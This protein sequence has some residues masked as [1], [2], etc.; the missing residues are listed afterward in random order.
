MHAVLVCFEAC[1]ADKVY[2]NAVYWYVYQL[3]ASYCGD[4]FEAQNE[5]KLDSLSPL[6]C[7]RSVR[8]LRWVLA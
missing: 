8:S 4:G 2:I 7:Y 1:G 3:Y 6:L 5:L